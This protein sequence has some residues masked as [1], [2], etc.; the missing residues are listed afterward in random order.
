MINQVEYSTCWASIVYDEPVKNKFINKCKESGIVGVVSPIH[1]RDT[2]LDQDGKTVYKKAHYHIM[3][4][5]KSKK[6]RNQ[7]KIFFDDLG[8]VGQEHIYNIEQYYYYLWHDQETDKAIYNSNDVEYVNCNENDFINE[9][10]VLK[11]IVYIIRNDKI[12]GANKLIDTLESYYDDVSPLM[13]KIIRQNMCLLKPMMDE[14]KK[15]NYESKGVEN[16][17]N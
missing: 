7:M 16:E 2:T 10:T 12:T 14:Y 15:R 3:V 5:F 4:K 9:S 13:F 17:S 8:S 6:S 11:N 1:D